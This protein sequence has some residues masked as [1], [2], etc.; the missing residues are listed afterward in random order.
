MSPSA[1]H[2]LRRRAVAV[3]ARSPNA[4]TTRRAVKASTPIADAVGSGCPKGVERGL[5]KGARQEIAHRL[6]EQ[7]TRTLKADIEDEDGGVRTDGDPDRGDG[8]DHADGAGQ[9]SGQ[10]ASPRRL[11]DEATQRVE[12]RH[13]PGLENL[14]LD[15]TL[16]R[17]T[18]SG[19]VRQAFQS[20][21]DFGARSSSAPHCAHVSACACKGATP[22]PPRRREKVN[23]VSKQVSC[24]SRVPPRVSTTAREG[25][26]QEVGDLVPA[27][28]ERRIH[29][30]L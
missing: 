24:G 27:S 23:F 18:E 13:V 1:F 21:D 10:Y 22:T 9:R 12:R 7:G 25:G 28:R 30:S 19:E 11:R 15:I 29:V 6:G 17:T 26:F 8:E 2:A 5:A 20:E 16:P 14:H 3:T 4:A